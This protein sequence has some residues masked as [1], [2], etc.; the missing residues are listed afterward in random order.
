MQR[1]FVATTLKATTLK[2][3]TDRISWG[4]RYARYLTRYLRMPPSERVPEV[5]RPGAFQNGSPFKV[6]L[7]CSRP[8]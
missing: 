5:S 8:G 1:G 3:F 2:Y 7:H 4:I 6:R